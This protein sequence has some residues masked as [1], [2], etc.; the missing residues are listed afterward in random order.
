MFNFSF[1]I[2]FK[3]SIVKCSLA[4]III[5]TFLKSTKSKLFSPC[6]GY[7]SKKGIIVSIN[8]EVF[9]IARLTVLLNL[10][11]C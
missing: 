3:P 5:A 8:S 6:M 2:L 11:I 10:D 4:P 1:K 7:F 9:V